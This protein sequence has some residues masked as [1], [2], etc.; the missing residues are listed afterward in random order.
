MPRETGA[1]P[2]DR[3]LHLRPCRSSIIAEY[4]EEVSRAAL[5]SKRRAVGVEKYVAPEGY[6]D[7]Y[8]HF[9]NFFEA[10]RTRKPVVEDAVFGFRAAGAALLSNL[11]IETRPGRQLGPRR[12]EGRLV[13]GCLPQKQRPILSV[14]RVGRKGWDT[15]TLKLSLS[16]LT[17][18]PDRRISPSHSARA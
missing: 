18:T 6:S 13:E 2:R 16:H 1:R 7:S 12:H 8:D 11:S 5:R 14:R 9:K 15:S 10:V 3:Q 4:R 17:T